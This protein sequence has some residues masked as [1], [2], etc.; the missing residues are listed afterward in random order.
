MKRKII[1]LLDDFFEWLDGKNVHIGD[2]EFCSWVVYS[3]E[4]RKRKLDFEPDCEN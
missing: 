3:R 1:N 2:L 4:K